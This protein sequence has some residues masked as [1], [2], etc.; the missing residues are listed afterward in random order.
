M[1]TEECLLQLG[2]G[3]VTVQG[4]VD[5]ALQA[6]A[7]EHFDFALLDHKLGSESSERVAEDLRARGIPFWLAT[8]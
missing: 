6:L 3:T 5:G 4:T 2:A 1:D 8:G 7:Q